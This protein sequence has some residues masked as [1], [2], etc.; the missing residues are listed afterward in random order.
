MMMKCSTEKM[1]KVVHFITQSY[2]QDNK[3]NGCTRDVLH[4]KKNRTTLKK[5]KKLQ[6]NKIKKSPKK[7]HKEIFKNFFGHTNRVQY[8]QNKIIF[9]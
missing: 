9:F 7:S 4:S 3:M 1:H 8:V 6:K 5:V 2:I